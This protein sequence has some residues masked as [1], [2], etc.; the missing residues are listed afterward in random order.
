MFSNA[1]QIDRNHFSLFQKCV[2]LYR[3]FTVL[4]RMIDVLNLKKFT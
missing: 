2:V 1:N 4:R 3:K